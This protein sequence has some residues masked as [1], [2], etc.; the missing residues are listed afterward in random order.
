MGATNIMGSIV[1]VVVGLAALAVAV[2]INDPPGVVLIDCSN[3]RTIEHASRL[4][5]NFRCVQ[6]DETP[7]YT[8]SGTEGC[9]ENQY[10]NSKTHECEQIERSSLAFPRQSSPSCPEGEVYVPSVDLCLVAVKSARP[11]ALSS[12]SLVREVPGFRMSQIIQLPKDC[13]ADEVYNSELSLC[14]KVPG[15]SRQGQVRPPALSLVKA[16]TPADSTAFKSDDHQSSDCG[17]GEYWIAELGICATTTPSLP[18]SANLIRAQSEVSFPSE[19][20]DKDCDS[21]ELFIP[22][23]GICAPTTPSKNPRPLVSDSLVKEKVKPFPTQEDVVC[24]SDEVYV[25]ELN[26]CAQR[27]KPQG[28]R[29]PSSASLV[30]EKQGPLEI[31]AF[32]D[33]QS[34]GD[35]VGSQIFISELGICS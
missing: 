13:A 30:K 10:F 4:R 23:L 8:L 31:T 24:A 7:S 22:E 26:I 18:Q 16:M 3:R 2:P 25:S 12:G 33:S 29:R 35:C 9:P 28:Q 6:Q 34:P 21:D 19:A 1:L 14:L 32:Q 27:A 15:R 17:E 20:S 5:Q 11:S